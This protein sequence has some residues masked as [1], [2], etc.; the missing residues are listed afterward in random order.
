MKTPACK[1][2]F[3]SE[4]RL[5]T[6]LTIYKCKATNIFFILRTTGFLSRQKP[7]KDSSSASLS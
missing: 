4:C 6:R 7:R 2:K 5:Q 1:N 3:T